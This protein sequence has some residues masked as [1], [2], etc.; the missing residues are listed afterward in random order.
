M[1]IKKVD[2][3]K[4]VNNEDIVLLR[5]VLSNE[6]QFVKVDGFNRDVLKGWLITLYRPEE[7]KSVEYLGDGIWKDT[8]T[9]KEYEIWYIKD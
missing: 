5:D 7:R 2:Q 6:R 3:A 4:D 1:Q 8:D 9:L